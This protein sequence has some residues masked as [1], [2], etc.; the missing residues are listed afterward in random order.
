M[1]TNLEVY[2]CYLHLP[3]LKGLLLV[4]F[5]T[6]LFLEFIN[7]YCIHQKSRPEAFAGS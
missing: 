6:L 2:F 1:F 7:I 4:F 3:G 5:I